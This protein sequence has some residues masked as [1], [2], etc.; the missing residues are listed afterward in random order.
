MKL[1]F[2]H[3]DDDADLCLV[4]RRDVDLADKAWGHWRPQ[5]FY[6]TDCVLNEDTSERATT[7]G[8]TPLVL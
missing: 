3:D 5:L 2:V 8:R 7:D 4:R 1:N 6:G